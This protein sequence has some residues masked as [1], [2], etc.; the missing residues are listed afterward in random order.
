VRLIV[1]AETGEVVQ[2]IDYDEYGQVNYVLNE[3]EFFDFTFAG[4]LYDTNTKLVRFGARDYDAE[5]GRWASKDPIL[6]SGGV[7]NLY[8]YVVNDPINFI[9]LNGKQLVE[10][11]ELGKEAAQSGGVIGEVVGGA[12]IAGGAIWYLGDVISDAIIDNNIGNKYVA[13]FRVYGGMSGLYGPS[14]T[15]V[16]PNL[17]CDKENYAYW[18]GLPYTNDMSNLA[19]GFV[20]VN[21]INEIK[22]ADPHK[23]RPGG[24]PEYVI[25]ASKTKV[26]LIKFGPWVKK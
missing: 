17:F 20:N 11:I 3:N 22:P 16:N 24:M 14:W 2:H 6:F 25:Y 9:D 23:D 18:A 4:G 10:A 1:N 19:M 5:T 13:V 8:E 26:H 15:P 21:D 7:S 12:I